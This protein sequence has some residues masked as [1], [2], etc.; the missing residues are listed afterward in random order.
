MADQVHRWSDKQLADL[1]RRVA[2][3]YAEAARTA[4]ERLR[5]HL[6]RFERQDEAKRKLV[7]EGKLDRDEYERWRKDQIVDTR[8]W[9]QVSKA[10][11]QDL[12][13][14][15]KIS[16]SIVNGQLPGVYAE[17]YNWG[18]YEVEHGTTIETAFSLYDASTVTRLLRD[19]PDLYP[20]AGVDEGKD[21]RWNSQHVTSAVT[22][23]LLLGEPMDKVAKRI[24]KV[25]DM[26][27]GTAMRAARTCVTSAENAGRVDSYTRAKS[28]GIEV[29]KQWLATLD[30]R[31]RS[32]HRALDGE[33]VEVDEPFSNGLM[34]PGDPSGPGKERYNCRCT[35]VADLKDFPAEQ[36][37]RA[38]KLGDMSYE[39]WKQ[40]H[41]DR[42][43][44]APA[45][46]G[47]L[48]PHVAEA[49][50]Q[51]YVDVT[52]AVERALREDEPIR[53]PEGRVY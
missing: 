7:D 41:R 52:E 14:A 34:Y 36:V 18:T 51:G 43:I 8:R 30:G 46:E 33:S 15:A 22:Q 49:L 17:N 16:M 4:E 11:A 25:A 1:E 44:P 47:A 50:G 38:S 31:T 37:N 48:L 40:E 2:E 39:E 10:L 12:T 5:E 13:N 32:S 42:T 26:S 9:K 27:A 53:A 35:L 23:G 28:L 29:K 3:A 45:Q 19:Q 6:R 20:R 21:V 24:S